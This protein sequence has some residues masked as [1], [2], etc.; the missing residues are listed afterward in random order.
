MG[1]DP[2]SRVD[3]QGLLYVAIRVELTDTFIVLHGEDGRGINLLTYVGSLR[4]R[5]PL[6][7]SSVF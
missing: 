4:S 7:I 5:M 1:G 6:V 2:L 3:P